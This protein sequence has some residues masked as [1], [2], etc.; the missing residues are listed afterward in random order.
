MYLDGH[1]SH[2]T[3]ALSNFCVEHEIELISLYPNSTHITQPM[4]VA[5]FRLLKE[6]WKK[7]VTDWRM[8]NGGIAIAKQNFAPILQ[9]ALQSL[10]LADILSHGFTAYGLAPL[11][12]DAIHY[13]KLLN[14]NL[15]L[16]QNNINTNSSTA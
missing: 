7:A 8:E 5:L 13:A 1:S 9:T 4:D 10:N 11:S 6:T 12:V 2:A 14:H 16:Q 15:V 3:M